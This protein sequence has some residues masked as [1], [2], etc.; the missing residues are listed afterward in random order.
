MPASSSVV[1]AVR[2]H[3]DFSDVGENKC[4][5]RGSNYESTHCTPGRAGP[6]G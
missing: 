2:K 5:A 4:N 3:R 6:M 1:V